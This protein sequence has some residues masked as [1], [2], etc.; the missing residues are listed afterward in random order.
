LRLGLG[1]VVIV[2]ALSVITG[3]NLF[4]E[5]GTDE[6]ADDPDRRARETVLERVAVGTFND[7]QRVF[8][9][10]LAV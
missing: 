7:E 3:R 6:P 9:E 5:I 4:E 10:T 1:G 8:R 2:L